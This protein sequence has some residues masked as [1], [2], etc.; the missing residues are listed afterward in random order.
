MMDYALLIVA[1]ILAGILN[2]IAGG[3]TFLTFPALVFVG[4]PPII[5][6]A[7]STAAALPGYLSS[8][9]G[10]REELRAFD[11]PQFLRLTV[12]T[13]LGGILGSGLLLVSSNTAFSFIVPFLLLGATIAF[14]YGEQIRKWA[15]SKSR[16]ITPFSAATMLAVAIYGGYF[17]GGLGIILLALFALWGMADIHLMN[18]MK[19]WLSFALS[20]ISVAIFAIAGL[21]AWPQA[22]TMMAGTTVGGYLGVSLSKAL[23]KR[24]VRGIVA[25]V[26]FGMSAVFFYRLV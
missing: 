21:I 9:V 1:S 4:V 8:A 17:N 6:N 10:F 16:S 13:L 19:S 7:T 12:L 5:A 2:T 26:G 24:L 14:L 15:S 20:A 22:L 25:A 23:P 3:G 11:R 18:G